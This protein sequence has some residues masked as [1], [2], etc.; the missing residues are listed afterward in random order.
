SPSFGLAL[1]CGD[2]Q[3]NKSYRAALFGSKK[4][5]PVEAR[6]AAR[7]AL[8][9]RPT[10]DLPLSLEL[11][12]LRQV[13][14]RFPAIVRQRTR[15]INHFHHLPSPGRARPPTPLAPGRVLTPLPRSPPPRLPPT[16]A[17]AALAAIASLPDQ[18][19]APLLDLA[20]SSIASLDGAAAAELVREQVRQ[21]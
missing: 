1:S 4:S 20:R 3:R 5:D 18:H 8:T 21:L 7:F 12:S 2:P 14:S 19:G 10:S 9:E 17:P 16:P 6:A 15:L 11:R 13:A